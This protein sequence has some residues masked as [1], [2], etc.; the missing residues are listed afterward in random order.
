MPREVFFPTRGAKMKARTG[1]APVRLAGLPTAWVLTFLAV[2]ALVAR[3]AHAVP[4]NAGAV[5][6][7]GRID[8]LVRRYVALRAFPAAV[9]L[10]RPFGILSIPAAEDRAGG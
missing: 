10:A 9:A 8:A 5:A 6:P 2:L 3:S 7:T 1:T 4:I